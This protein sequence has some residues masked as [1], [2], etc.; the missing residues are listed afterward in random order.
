[1]QM[2]YLPP[3]FVQSFFLLDDV[4]VQLLLLMVWLLMVMMLLMHLLLNVAAAFTAD[5]A[6]A[7]ANDAC[8]LECCYYR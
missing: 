1:M 4:S 8:Y 2:F 5:A 7:I 6:V 3:R